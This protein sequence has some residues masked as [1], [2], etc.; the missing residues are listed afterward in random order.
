VRIALHNAFFGQQVAETELARRITV[1]AG[2]LGWEAR[3]VATS[4]EIIAWQ[5]DFVLAL[6]FFTP[7]LTAFPTYGCMWNP[8]SALET[9]PAFVRNVLGY[10][11]YLTSCERTNEWIRDLLDG[12][13]KQ[14]FFA[15]LYTSWP[16]RR[17]R[18]PALDAPRLVYIGTNWD[19]ARYEAFFR[20]L[21][22]RP[23]LDVYGPLGR[24][25]HATQAHRG[26]LP[27]DGESVL[28]VL[29]R[30]GV[31]LCLHRP[32]HREAG[33]PS[34]RIFEIACSGA[35]AICQ[36]HPFIREKFGD[37]VLYLSDGLEPDALAQQIEDRMRWIEAHRK[38]AVEM[39]R[40]AH[41]VFE[42]HLSLETCLQEIG[43]RHPGLVAAKGLSRSHRPRSQGH[44]QVVVRTGGRPAAMLARA[45]SSIAE[46]TYPDVS[47]LVVRHG[48]VDVEPA[49]AAC[50]GRLEVEVIDVPRGGARSQSLWAGL[51]AATGDFIANLDDDDS[52][53]PNHLATLVPL[54]APGRRTGLA[55]S[56]TVRRLEQDAATSPAPP[57]E[58]ASL[59]YHQPF[60]R[61]RLRALDNYITSNAWV[62]RREIAKAAG[63]DPRL[64]V[65]ED[66]MLLLRFAEVSDFAFSGEVTA[67]F[68]ER[69]SRTDNTRY[70]GGDAWGIAAAR[71]RA[72][73]WKHGL[74]RPPAPFPRAI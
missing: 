53:F 9:D 37:A 25:S 35:V 4:G 10:D 16:S 46:Q 30:S 48:E 44:V 39:S 11:A 67:Q 57:P 56:G 40:Q 70:V 47:A 12:L 3:E 45:L 51:A 22:E 7:K 55:Y 54:V 17:W 59:A 18:A 21:A 69:T 36:E 6:H 74:V 29:N 1:A 28:D 19:G 63:E 60:D 33:I 23:F 58:P 49:L 34:L 73:L 31:G 27:F 38:Q 24:W 32:E 50:R 71:I 5:P 14:T 61:D 2:R 13:G 72:M 64:D 66:L 62:A 20:S 65:L 26:P 41:A 68:F 15:P 8:P 52:W 42:R 43:R